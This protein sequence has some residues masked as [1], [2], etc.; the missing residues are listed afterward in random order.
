M[1]TFSSI[2]P[3]P[4]TPNP[5]GHCQRIWWQ[6]P[7]IMA[8]EKICLDLSLPCHIQTIQI[9]IKMTGIQTITQ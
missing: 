9:I 5:M 1:L 3:Q 4:W 7:K 8:R 6:R 2:F